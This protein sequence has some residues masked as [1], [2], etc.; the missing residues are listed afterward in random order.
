MHLIGITLSMC[1]VYRILNKPVRQRD[2]NVPFFLHK[3]ILV[4]IKMYSMMQ[5]NKGTIV[6][7]CNLNKTKHVLYL[8]IY[9]N[10]D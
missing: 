8:L 6:Q 4:N 3:H 2:A 1:Y 7:V 5:V 9:L 10:K